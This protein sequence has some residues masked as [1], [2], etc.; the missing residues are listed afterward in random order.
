[1]LWLLNKAVVAEVFNEFALSCICGEG[2]H[3]KKN[4]ICVMPCISECLCY[5]YVT[6]VEPEMSQRWRYGD[7]F[8]TAAVE[9]SL[10]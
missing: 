6:D 8:S 1:M 5:A 3:K 10:I 4:M 9:S 7:S 2:N